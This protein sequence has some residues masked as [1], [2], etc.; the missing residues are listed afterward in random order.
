MSIQVQ[1]IKGYYRG[2]LVSGIF[3]LVKPYQDGGRGGFITIK[4]SNPAPGTPPTQRITVEKGDFK[5]LDANGA[6]LGEHITID[7]GSKGLG[8]QVGT[9]YE[10]VFVAAET[11][12]E[13]MERIADAGQNHRCMFSKR[14]ARLGCFGTSGYR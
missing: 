12:D 6:E 1:I 2:Q 7:N 14:G 3:P 13:A 5:L 8:P 9:D 10:S 11:E 4:N